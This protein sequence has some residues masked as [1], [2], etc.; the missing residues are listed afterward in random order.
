MISAGPDEGICF[1]VTGGAVSDIK[2]G[3]K[4]IKETEFNENHK[5]LAMDKGYSAYVTIKMCE[6]K[7]LIAVVPPKSSFKNPWEYHHWIYAYRNEIERLFGRIKHCRRVAMRF[8]KLA[9]RYSAFV[10]LS[11]ILR[12][13]K[14]YV[15]TA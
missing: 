13:L 2:A 14:V 6:E 7:D 12:F 3:L 10:T 5:W 1:S 8:D 4:L 11:L 9:R 15:N